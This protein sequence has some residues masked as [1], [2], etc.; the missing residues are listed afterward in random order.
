MT[1]IATEST[2][3]PTSA[4]LL[5][6][7]APFTDARFTAKG[8]PR[9]RVSLSQLDTLWLNTGTQ[10][11]IACENCYIESTPSNDRLVYLTLA[12]VLVFLDEIQAEGL[13]TKTIGITGGEPFMNPDILAIAEA[14]LERGFDLLI[15]TNA[16]RPMMRPKIQ[17]GLLDLKKRF[18]RQLALRV[19]VDHFDPVVHEAERG[20]RSWQPMVTGLKWLQRNNFVFHIAGRTRWGDSEQALRQGFANTL[21]ELGITLDSNDAHDL[22]LFPEI[23]PSAHVPEITTACWGILGVNPQDMMCAS[24]RM[25]VKHKGNSE[26]SV[27]ACTLLPYEP[28]FNLGQ[29]LKDA[30]GSVALNHPSCA[31]FCVLGGGS[32][33]S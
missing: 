12:D 18:G 21:E 27:M 30:A 15:L 32:C 1:I 5:D 33:S 4:G 13:G 20:P 6:A 9:A 8:E 2:T 7:R 10:C 16:M 26:P 3:S 11:N 28:E 22:V 24:S 19:S 31:K 29:S 23:D 14:C 25:V 17:A